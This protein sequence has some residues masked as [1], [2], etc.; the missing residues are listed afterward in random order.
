MRPSSCYS[1]AFSTP[2]ILTA[3][4]KRP[5]SFY[6]DGL[7]IAKPWIC[8]QCYYS[9]RSLHSKINLSL[10]KLSLQAPRLSRTRNAP[11][12]LLYGQKAQLSNASEHGSTKQRSELPSQEEHRRSHL[13]KRFSNV[14][15]HLQS[16]IFIAG[17]R[18]NDLTGYSGIE[19]LKKE[20]ELQGHLGA[21]NHHMLEC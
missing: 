20:I 6:Y 9:Q 18:L 14:M 10:A 13:S 8:R 15:D 11:R 7:R 1:P 5:L 16:N 4:S 12:T 21:A 2:S 17:Q 3:V 19:I